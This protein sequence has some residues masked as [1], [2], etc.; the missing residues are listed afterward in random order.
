MA[1]LSAQIQSLAGSVTESEIDQ[2]CEDAVRELINLFPPNLKEMCY[3]K[4]TFTSAAAN[5]EAETIA[6][7]HISNVFAGD[8]QC[9]EIHPRNKYKASDVDSI[10]YATSTDPVYYIEGSKINILPAS[11]SGIYYAIADPSITASSDSAISNFPNEAEYLVV[12][13]AAIKVLQNKMNE[14]DTVT[15]IDTT[16]FDATNTE[17]D[18]TQ[19][20]CD[21]INTQVD[22]AVSEIAE[23]ATQVDAGVDTALAAIAT[24]AGRI[25]T[26]VGL[27][28]GQ[29]D[30]GVLEAAQAE[31][32]ADDAAIATALTAINTNIDSAITDIGLAKTEAAEIATQTDNSGKIETALDAMNTE[33]D[34]VDEICSEANVEFDKVDNVI[35]E[36][37]VE[38]DKST[39]LLDLGETDTEGAVNTALAA[40]VTELNETQAVCDLIN[41]EV[42]KAFAEVALAKTEAAEIA[43]QTDNSGDFATALTAINT[44]VDKFQA[45]GGDPA[46]FGDET[47]YLTGVGLAHVKDALE[48]AR[49]AI[50]TGFTTDEDA[51]SGDAT[52]YSVGYWLA[53]EDTEMVQATLQTAQTEIQRAQAHISEWNATVQALQAEI[54]GFATEVQSR[55]AFTGAKGQAVQAYISTANGYIQTAQGYMS[56]LQ[57]KIS[58]SGGYS[59]EVQMRLA[60][61]QAKRQESQSRLAA[62]S[63]YIQEA[64]SIISQGNAYLQEAQSRISQANG[65]AQEV[66]ARGGFTQAKFQAV[67]SYINTAGAF[68]QASQA[69]ASEVQAYS[70][71]VG[72]FKMT[73][74]NRIN[75]GN[76]FLQEAQASAQEAQA[77]VSEVNARVAQIGGYS[78][79]VSGYLNSAQGYANEIQSKIGIAQ[80]YIAEANTRMQR[81]SQKYQWYQ[82]QQQKLQQDYNQGVT[83]LI[84]APATQQGK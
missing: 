30:A 66:N 76:A 75:L 48:L 80:G 50:D 57:A 9:R 70:N 51:G 58:I 12:L 34:K 36:G 4:N 81:E 46:L 43:T 27:A 31:G 23:A 64:Q 5:S 37:S 33:L 2:W 41:G 26:A 39:A 74:E 72:I 3:A 16:A 59:Q 61:A 82:S 45:D 13:Y 40:M 6:T 47:Q 77:Y 15:A 18:E 24:A 10:E 35:I 78:Q 73:S 32:E 84:G 20:I 19:A 22:A 54:N 55:A 49:D 63:A 69:F 14:M 17:L 62:G 11:S 65:Y 56:E 7:Q 71:S 28:N 52:P 53:D 1:T 68:I 67:Q 8:V 38:I 44:A 79:V 83:A 60:Q 25:N 42:D 29:F 21:L